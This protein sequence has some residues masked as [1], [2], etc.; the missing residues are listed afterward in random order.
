MV[1]SVSAFHRN[2]TRDESTW[3]FPIET[4]R[5][6]AIIILVSFHVIGGTDG[7]GLGLNATHPLRIYADLLVDLRMPLFAFVSGLVYAIRP[8]APENLGIF[9]Q[10][11]LRR[12]VLPGAVAM[13]LFAVAAVTTGAASHPPDP[14]WM[15]YFTGYSIFWFLQAI[16]LI[17]FSVGVIDILSRGKLLL[18]MLVGASLALCVGWTFS[19]PIMSADRAT[20][21]LPYFLLGAFFVRNKNSLIAQRIPILLIALTAMMVGLTMNIATFIETGEFSTERL[22]PQSFLFGSGACVAA[23][24]AFP[25]IKYLSRLGAYS[26]TIYLYH[27]FFTSGSRKLLFSLGIESPYMHFFVGTI[28]GILLPATLHLF[29]SRWRPSRQVLLGLR[30]VSVSGRPSLRAI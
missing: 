6:V 17:F 4:V 9:L 7:R 18:P 10:G 2:Q 27:I 25:N 1:K 21:L 20:S 5:A 29:A 22:D 11:K 26:F 19:S 13:T 28:M 14:I 30:P 23:I 24:L 8:V 16:L 3:T 12:L 15:M